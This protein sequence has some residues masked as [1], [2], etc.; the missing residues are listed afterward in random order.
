M[1]VSVYSKSRG[2]LSSTKTLDQFQLNHD[3]AV[4]STITAKQISVSAG[5]D[6][7]IRGSNV[8]SDEET[9]IVAAENVSLTAAQNHYCDNEFHQTKKSGLMSSGGIGFAIGSKKTTDDTDSTSLTHTG[10]TVGSIK[11]DT[12]IV[13]GKHYEQ[14]G[15]TVSS[16]E[17]NNTIHAQSIDIQAAHNQLNSNTTQT[18]EQKA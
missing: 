10:S 6:V 12:T 3:E 14:I 18:Y 9:Q 15:S 1:D 13:A 5:K 7:A 17:G 2:V 8:I 4:G 16:P 11:G